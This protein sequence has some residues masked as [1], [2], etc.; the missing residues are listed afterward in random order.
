MSL[1]TECMDA[2]QATD[3]DT[4][5]RNPIFIE[6]FIDVDRPFSA[7]QERFSGDGKW[8]APL[9]TEATREGESLRMRIGPVWAAHVVTHEV[10]V[11]LWP[12]RE[13]DSS[14]VRSLTWVPSGWQ[15]LFPLLDGD[16]EL[17]PID[18]MW[19]RLSLAVAYTPP[20]ARC[21]TAS[22]SRPC[23]PFSP[24]PPRSS[25]AASTFRRRSSSR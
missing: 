18:S 10:H 22:P 14:L 23:A 3:L 20:T 4:R 17:A 13:R 11:T 12:P 2:S 1:N 7:L 25:R 5:R 21:F 19:C 8:L 24:K 16:I 9:A 6:D 15:S